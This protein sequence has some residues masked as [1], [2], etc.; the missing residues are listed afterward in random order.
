MLFV[1]HENWRTWRSVAKRPAVLV[2][3]KSPHIMTKQSSMS[4]AIVTLIAL[5]AA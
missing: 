1:R 2:K 5:T 3:G 4:F